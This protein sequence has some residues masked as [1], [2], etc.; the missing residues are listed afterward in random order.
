[1]LPWLSNSTQVSIFNSDTVVWITTSFKEVQTAKIDAVT[2]A[3]SIVQF[4]NQL[5]EEHRD[6]IVDW[7][8][9]ANNI[10]QMRIASA[11]QAQSNVIMTYQ[12]QKD[13]FKFSDQNVSAKI[14][15]VTGDFNKVASV[16]QKSDWVLTQDIVI[17][18]LLDVLI[19]LQVKVLF[20]N[21]YK[22][23]TSAWAMASTARSFAKYTVKKTCNNDYN[24]GENNVLCG[25]GTFAARDSESEMLISAIDGGLYEL[26]APYV[27]MT[28][29]E[30]NLYRAFT[31]FAV[32]ETIGAIVTSKLRGEDFIQ[33]E[34]IAL[35]VSSLLALD[36]TFIQTPL[37]SYVRDAMDYVYD[38]FDGVFGNVQDDVPLVG[39]DS[40][41]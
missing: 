29:E 16:T 17:D 4:Q 20:G 8:F 18:T 25:I 36:I 13:F 24:P 12:E 40:S 19:G 33:N 39:S 30:E 31:I 27:G 32:V 35:S 34:I 14:I 1:M 3:D 23:L 21:P 6:Q 28:L 38:V 2:L 9:Y 37:D 11:K 41:Y 5:T 7:L 15:K 26:I 10:N 22:D